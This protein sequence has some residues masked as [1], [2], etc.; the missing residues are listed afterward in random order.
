[1]A[2]GVLYYQISKWVF[3]MIVVARH[4]KINL[5]DVNIHK[6]N[7]LHFCHIFLQIIKSLSH[8]FF[9]H[10]YKIFIKFVS[11]FVKL[12]QFLTQFRIQVIWKQTSIFLSVFLF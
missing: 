11:N 5:F 1:M 2:F 7:P 10:P 12:R 6:L 3:I 8:L 9:G 4:N